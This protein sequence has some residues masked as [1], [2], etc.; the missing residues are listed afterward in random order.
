M[1]NYVLHTGGLIA[2]RS[3]ALRVFQNKVTLLRARQALNEREGGSLGELYAASC[4]LALL[5]MFA[6]LRNL[7]V[8]WTEGRRIVRDYASDPEVRAAVQAFPLSWRHPALALAVLAVR[9][10]GV[11]CVYT[12]AWM[13]LAP[14]RFRLRAV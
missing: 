2:N 6:L 9:I 4:V 3:R 5:E 10:L 8:G 7:R 1:Y 14:F 13:L 11:G 12:L